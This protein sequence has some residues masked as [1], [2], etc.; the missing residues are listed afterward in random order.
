MK[1]NWKASGRLLL[2]ALFGFFILRRAWRFACPAAPSKVA[3]LRIIAV[4]TAVTGGPPRRSV[5][6]ELP[7]TAL[8]LSRARNRCSG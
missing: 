7:H 5:R 1:N 2:H 4:G 6:E 3:A 8:A